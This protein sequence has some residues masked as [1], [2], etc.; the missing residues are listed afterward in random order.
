M[1]GLIPAL[2]ASPAPPRRRADTPVA[3]PALPPGAGRVAVAGAPLPA[4]NPGSHL[5]KLARART[6]IGKR[7]SCRRALD[8]IQRLGDRVELG[9][10]GGAVALHLLRG[11]AQVGD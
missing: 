10:Q 11:L 9:L 5:F 8:C 4:T 2:V 3:A 7:A 6:R 1:A